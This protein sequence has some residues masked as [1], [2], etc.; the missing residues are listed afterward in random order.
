MS[1]TI[2]P[3][4][5]E[6]TA[7]VTRFNMLLAE[8]SEGKTLDQA[9]VTAGVRAILSDS[10]KGLYFLAEREGEIV[11]QLMISLEWSDWRNGWIWW[12]QSVYVQSNA[13]RQGVFRA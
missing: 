12:L 10:G 9:T 13:R 8:E 7:I 3:G 6:D 11:G 2:R 1:L 4:R 5:P